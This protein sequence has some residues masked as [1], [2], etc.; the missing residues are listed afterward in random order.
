MVK[1][2]KENKF[3]ETFPTKP[4]ICDALVGGGVGYIPYKMAKNCI[5]EI[6]LVDEDD[7]GRAVSF[8]IRKEKK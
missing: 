3:Y 4:S 7:I 5:D 2:L 6:I 1:S 8:L